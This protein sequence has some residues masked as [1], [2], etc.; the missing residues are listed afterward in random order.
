MAIV[1]LKST[2][3]NFTFLIK[4]NPNTGMQ[5]RSVRKGIAYGWYTD[6]AVFNVYFKD[7]DNEISY[8][9]HENENFEYLN[10]SRYNTPL[11]PL[12]AIN[13]FFS[14]PLKG[15]DERDIEGYEH[16]FFIPFIHIEMMR[17]IDYFAKHLKDY[18]FSIEHQAHKSY[19][20]T[21]TTS[22]SVYQLLHVV[23]VLCL[24][25]SM[26]SDEYIDISDNILDKYIRSIN[27][28]D[29][30]FY[31]RSLFVRNFL[32]T[33]ERFKRYKSVVEQTSRYEIRF[34][35][36]GTALQ[37]RSFISSQLPFNKPILDIGCGE[38]YYA[39]PL[40]GK[41]E[42]SY[43]AIDI[44]EEL[45]EIVK[46]KAESKQIDNI[47]T[48]NAIDGFLAAYNGE[49]VDIIL[50]EVIEHMSKEEAQAFILHIGKEVSFDRFIITTPNSDFNLYYELSEFRHDDH[51][52]EMGTVA[53]QQWFSSMMEGT[54]Y[55]FEF[56]A[57]GDQVNG[58]QT[59][60]GV[61]LQGKG[62]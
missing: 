21:V 12:N 17:Y 25:L 40:A 51:K 7:A 50:T 54:E 45:L 13:E 41:L 20:L 1:Q 56:V 4:K 10:V 2:N 16:T 47:I 27:V 39:I 26:F 57:I 38:G 42:N 52:W 37:R 59:T 48:F 46:R 62:D 43:Y 22:K 44:N 5:L 31:I 11:F 8:K 61:I 53:F 35:F 33:R 60:Q 23:S 30:P 3:P 34:D 24:F 49:Q 15:Q 36:G 9:Q 55:T 14:H 58:I 19:S 29:A 18:S 28:I 6:D 32:S